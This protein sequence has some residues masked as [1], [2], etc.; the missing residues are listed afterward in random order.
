MVCDDPCTASLPDTCYSS[1]HSMESA[2]EY[3]VRYSGMTL[4]IGQTPLD[5]NLLWNPPDGFGVSAL[6]V[7]EASDLALGEVRMRSVFF[8]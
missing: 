4:P 3:G 2:G 1:L 8:P 6:S 7:V 5:I